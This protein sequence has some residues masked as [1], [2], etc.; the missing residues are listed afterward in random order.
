[1]ANL[2][3][4]LRKELAEAKAESERL[5]DLVVKFQRGGVSHFH[6]QHG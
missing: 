4:Q 1:M 5:R 3:E 6:E 2:I